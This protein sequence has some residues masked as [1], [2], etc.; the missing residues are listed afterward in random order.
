[1]AIDTSGMLGRRSPNPTH[2]HEQHEGL[3]RELASRIRFRGPLTVAEYIALSNTHP[4]FG[5]YM[6]P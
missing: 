5:Y 3:M 1:V 4:T 2:T 6:S